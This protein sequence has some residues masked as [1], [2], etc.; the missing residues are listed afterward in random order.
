MP[1]LPEVVG[2]MSHRHPSL[3]QLERKVRTVIEQLEPV[4]TSV[5][6]VIWEC[7]ESKHSELLQQMERSLGAAL[8]LQGA[9]NSDGAQALRRDAR[10]FVPHLAPQLSDV[11]EG[12]LYVVEEQILFIRDAIMGTSVDGPLLPDV[13]A[14]E[15]GPS[16]EFDW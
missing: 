8:S 14:G 13:E 3:S 11:V 1:Q 12:A 4:A 15:P 16:V 6:T 5:A 2:H 10:R 7:D 9:L